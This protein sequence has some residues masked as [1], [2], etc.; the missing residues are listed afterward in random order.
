MLLTHLSLKEAKDNT[1]PHTEAIWHQGHVWRSAIQVDEVVR[2]DI[3]DPTVENSVS[4]VDT[5]AQEL[6]PRQCRQ[7]LE[8]L[9]QELPTLVLFHS[10]NMSSRNRWTLL[11]GD[12]IQR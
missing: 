11:C 3:Q 9:W 7:Q 12:L 5:P 1:W 4:P 8:D 2:L 10:A 6:G